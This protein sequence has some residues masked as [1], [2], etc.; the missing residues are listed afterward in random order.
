M[1]IT[2]RC[3][4]CGFSFTV[5]YS[6]ADADRETAPALACGQCRSTHWASQAGS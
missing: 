2:L 5:T 1:T 4:N 3:L 6:A